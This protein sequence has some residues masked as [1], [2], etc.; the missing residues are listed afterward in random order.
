[1]ATEWHITRIYAMAIDSN[2]CSCAND[3]TDQIRIFVIEEHIWTD[4]RTVRAMPA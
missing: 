3:S 1:M 2:Y 4:V